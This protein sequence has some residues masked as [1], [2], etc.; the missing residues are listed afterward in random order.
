MEAYSL[1]DKDSL[2]RYTCAIC[3][4]IFSNPYLISHCLHIY[5]L[6]CINKFINFYTA[7]TGKLEFAPLF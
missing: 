4:E 3:L 2:E 6:D 5:C 1:I 7:K